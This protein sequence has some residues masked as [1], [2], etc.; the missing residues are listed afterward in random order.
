M[1]KGEK[2]KS[3]RKKPTRSAGGKASPDQA[4]QQP[5]SR[6]DP[7]GE[8][9]SSNA[10]SAAA[11]RV[12]QE[13]YFSG[14]V[15]PPSLLQSYEEIEPGLA[16]RLVRMTEREQEHA[17]KMDRR[18]LRNEYLADHAGRF[19]GLVVALAFLFVAA[20]LIDR[21]HDW[22]GLALGVVDLAALV[23]V[24]VYG[25]MYEHGRASKRE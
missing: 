7:Q 25:R 1:G 2:R 15:P 4:S 18:L 20:W 16:G 8:S 9:N 14:P 12:Q 17:H 24:F 11:V 13:E 23:S 10:S 3:K 21:G 19:A 6:P 22:P 5:D